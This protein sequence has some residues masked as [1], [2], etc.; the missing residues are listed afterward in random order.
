MTDKKEMVQRTITAKWVGPELEYEGYDAKGNVIKMGGGAF[1]PSELLLMGVA[2]C[3]GMD[4]KSILTKKKVDF[5]TIEISVTGHQPTRYPKPYKI[6][7]IHFKVTGKNVPADAVE[8][9]IYL[10]SEK[11]CIASQTLKNPTE[12]TT[13]FEIVEA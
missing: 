9:A 11:Y 12:V 4:V 6:V 3:T 2:G 7:N 10:S 8:R 5:E 1:S 13:S